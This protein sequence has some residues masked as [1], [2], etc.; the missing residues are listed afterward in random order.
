M[1]I[2]NKRKAKQV[3]IAGEELNKGDV[4]SYD[5]NKDGK[6]IIKKAKPVKKAK[7]QKEKP[8]EKQ[9]VEKYVNRVIKNQVYH[10]RV[11]AK[12]FKG[13]EYKTVSKKLWMDNDFYFSVVFQSHEQKYEFIN[14]L[15]EKYGDKIDVDNDYEVQIINGLLLAEAFGIKLKKEMTKKYPTGNIELLPFVLDNEEI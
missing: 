8:S 12:K 15:K 11:D 10:G 4:V 5:P 2:I 9:I 7:V 3:G 1:N 6:Q 13:M 14:A